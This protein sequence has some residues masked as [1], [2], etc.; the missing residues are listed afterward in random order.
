MEMFATMDLLVELAQRHRINVKLDI[1][2][3]LFFYK[4]QYKHLFHYDARIPK[5]TDLNKNFLFKNQPEVYI[6]PYEAA[7]VEAYKMYLPNHDHFFC[8]KLLKSFHKKI[9]YFSGIFT[10]R[11]S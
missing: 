1:L 10:T 8:F 2:Q 4:S 5:A 6:V 3:Q 11:K 7:D 9:L